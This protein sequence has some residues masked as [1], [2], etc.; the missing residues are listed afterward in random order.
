MLL[1]RAGDLPAGRFGVRVE[2]IVV[3]TAGGARRLDTA[4]HE[5]QVVA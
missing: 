1:D 3:V 2:D 5:M 4:T